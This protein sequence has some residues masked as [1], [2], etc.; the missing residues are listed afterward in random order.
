MKQFREKL[1]EKVQ[2]KVPKG[3]LGGFEDCQV[4]N[5]PT[6]FFEIAVNDRCRE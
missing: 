4:H 3:I 1:S 5:F 6:T 2:R